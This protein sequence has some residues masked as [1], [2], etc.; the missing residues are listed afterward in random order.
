MRNGR[1]STLILLV[2]GVVS[3]LLLLAYL[4]Y[5]IDRMPWAA[6]G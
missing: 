1:K 3:L 5:L 6:A 2:A 4:A